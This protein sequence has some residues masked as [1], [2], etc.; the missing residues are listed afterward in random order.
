MKLKYERF[1]GLGC[2]YVRGPVDEK[3]AKLLQ[4]G[5][6][7]IAKDLEE[8]LIINLTQASVLAAVLPPL[9]EFKKKTA[10]AAKHKIYWVGKDRAIADFPNVDVLI[11][12]MSGAKSRQIGE[13]IHSDDRFYELTEKSHQLDAQITQLGGN[14]ENTNKLI[15]ENTTLKEQK[16]LLDEFIKFQHARAKLQVPHPPKD[17]KEVKTK[18]SEAYDAIRLERKKEFDL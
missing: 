10:A 12:R 16:R 4:V 18:T 14:E 5:I 7:T 15:Y 3:Y 13:H 17:E 2:L 9:T 8:T 1:E 11:S 6:E